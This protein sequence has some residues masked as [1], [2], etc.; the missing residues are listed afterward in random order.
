MGLPFLSVNRCD[1]NLKGLPHFKALGMFSCICILGVLLASSA[2]DEITSKSSNGVYENKDL[3]KLTSLGGGNVT[4]VS[5]MSKDII[6]ENCI[7]RSDEKL[8]LAKTDNYEKEES[9]LEKKIGESI[10]CLCELFA[11]QIRLIDAYT[12]GAMEVYCTF[13]NEEIIKSNAANGGSWFQKVKIAKTIAWNK[14]KRLIGWSKEEVFPVDKLE[15]STIKK[16]VEIFIKKFETELKVT[17]SLHTEGIDKL[18]CLIGKSDEILEIL[19]EDFNFINYD[20]ER[21]STDVN[22]SN[23]KKEA[24]ITRKVRSKHLNVTNYSERCIK[25][26]TSGKDKDELLSRTA[27]VEKFRAKRKEAVEI[28]RK[29][30][31]NLVDSYAE[32]IREEGIA[33]FLK[34]VRKSQNLIVRAALYRDEG[35]LLHEEINPE[36]REGIK[37]FMAASENISLKIKLDDIYHTCFMKFKEGP[38]CKEKL[39]EVISFVKNTYLENESNCLLGVAIELKDAYLSLTKHFLKIDAKMGIVKCKVIKEDIIKEQGKSH[40]IDRNNFIRRYSSPQYFSFTTRGHDGEVVEYCVSLRLIVQ[41]ENTNETC[42][43][44]EHILRLAEISPNKAVA[45]SMGVTKRSFLNSELEDKPQCGKFLVMNADINHKTFILKNGV[46]ELFRFING[47]LRNQ[48]SEIHSSSTLFLEASDQITVEASIIGDKYVVCMLLNLLRNT[49]SG[50]LHGPKDS[51]TN[52]DSGSTN[53]IDPMSIFLSY[54][55]YCRSISKNNS[56]QLSDKYT[57]ECI[58]VSSSQ[59]DILNKCQ[60]C[61]KLAGICKELSAKNTTAKVKN[62]GKTKITVKG[63]KQGVKVTTDLSSSPGVA[64]DNKDTEDKKPKTSPMCKCSICKSVKSE[65]SMVFVEKPAPSPNGTTFSSAKTNFTPE[66]KFHEKFERP[67]GKFSK[68]KDKPENEKAKVVKNKINGE[69]RN[70]E[71]RKNEDSFYRSV[72][73]IMFGISMGC[74]LATAIK[75]HF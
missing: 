14:I 30:L 18:M 13:I 6:L 25:C 9:L 24:V 47:I 38:V 59:N 3:Q 41:E 21:K 2:V 7:A 44:M 46:L 72:L 51:S 12:K 68:A 15:N 23:I 66:N 33:R 54:R 74:V 22:P 35:I 62:F 73:K 65:P 69:L 16:N 50:S 1:E 19:H 48:N 45:I 61:I 71:T 67:F 39:D 29:E 11:L 5:G 26:S 43:P 8:K 10:G 53:V 57:V 37:K 60:R 70:D 4:A 17:Q 20:L 64:N 31:S 36:I 34:K 42:S 28:E 58:N 32:I 40:V 75:Y 63:S 49:C 27:L 56:E 55:A 52:N